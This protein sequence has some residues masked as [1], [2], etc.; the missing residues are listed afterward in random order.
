[1]QDIAW[2]R[3][4]LDQSY[5]LQARREQL[6]EERI[7]RA[8]AKRELRLEML[9]STILEEQLQNEIRQSQNIDHRAL[10]RE[11]HVEEQ[12]KEQQQELQQLA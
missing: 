10:Q 6:L 11:Q 12:I 5:K 8:A 2:L 3:Q 7:Q 4:Q 9:R 1:M